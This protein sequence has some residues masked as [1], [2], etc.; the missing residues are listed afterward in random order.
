[1]TCRFLCWNK[2]KIS[3]A[4]LY[5]STFVRQTLNIKKKINE[6]NLNKPQTD[7][8]GGVLILRK[9]SNSA[10][11]NSVIVLKWWVIQFLQKNF[12]IFS[13]LGSE[14]EILTI[15]IW[16]KIF[17]NFF[18]FWQ[19]RP[20]CHKPPSAGNIPPSLRYFRNFG[21]S[22]EKW[23]VSGVAPKGKEGAQGI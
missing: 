9:S 23:G 18:V 12:Y 7:R 8:F 15:K 17:K 4:K 11:K 16:Q 14:T 21:Q 13:I 22:T 5:N 19:C 6:I 20:S 3:E 2:W 1:M 10:P